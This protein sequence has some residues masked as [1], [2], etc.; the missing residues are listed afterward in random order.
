[1]AKGKAGPGRGR[2]AEDR[3]GMKQYQSLLCDDDDDDDVGI[4]TGT[5]LSRR[6]RR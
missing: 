5:W 6:V 4:G 2:D 3:S 1:M